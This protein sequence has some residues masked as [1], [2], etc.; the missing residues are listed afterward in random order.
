MPFAISDYNT[1]SITSA[2][3]CGLLRTLFKNYEFAKLSIGDFYEGGYLKVLTSITGFSVFNKYERLKKQSSAWTL[4]NDIV[5]TG[6]TFEA[7]IPSYI[8]LLLK[9]AMFLYK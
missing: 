4:M 8:A 2:F 7:A 1:L 5:I 9:Y 3:D 6:A